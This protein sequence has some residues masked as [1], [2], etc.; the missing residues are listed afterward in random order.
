MNLNSCSRRMLSQQHHQIQN[1]NQNLILTL[2]LLQNRMLLLQSSFL[3]PDRLWLG[4]NS[5]D[6]RNNILMKNPLDACDTSSF[7]HHQNRLSCLFW[8]LN[9]I[10]SNHSFSSICETC[11]K[12]CCENALI[13][14]QFPREDNQQ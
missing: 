4:A 3:Y 5:F 9:H 11:S 8:T 10:S 12:N 2:I 1:Q 13:Y 14:V 7:C 6:E